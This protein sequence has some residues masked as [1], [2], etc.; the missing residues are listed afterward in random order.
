MVHN[1]SADSN[2]TNFEHDII[3]HTPTERPTVLY[4]CC[5]PG[6]SEFFDEKLST[7]EKRQHHQHHHQ[8]HNEHTNADNGDTNIS[9]RGTIVRRELRYEMTNIDIAHL[10]ESK[11]CLKPKRNI[12]SIRKRINKMIQFRQ[13]QRKKKPT[14]N[15]ITST[16][17]NFLDSID[18]GQECHETPQNVRK[19][20]E[21]MRQENERPFGGNNSFKNQ[22]G[23]CNRVWHHNWELLYHVREQHS[24]YRNWF[25]RSYQCGMCSSS[26]FLNRLL[27]WHSRRNHNNEN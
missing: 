16:P 12:F 8:Q 1:I 22:C 27:I 9:K 11:D 15:I 6:L 5:T 21:S 7:R 14:D 4:A 18:M 19:W 13:Q 17:N 10:K 23:H 26:F 25:R 3:N 20:R 24:G 2:F